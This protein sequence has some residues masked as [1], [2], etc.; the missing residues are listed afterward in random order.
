MTKTRCRIYNSGLI[1][2]TFVVFLFTCPLSDKYKQY[3]N[4]DMEVKALYLTC[5]LVT[6][7]HI[8]YGIC[9][10]SFFKPDFMMHLIL[11][12]N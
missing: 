10:V 11:N 8:H 2:L 7:S 12:I 4:A 6:L 3:L 5:L 1:L 9:V